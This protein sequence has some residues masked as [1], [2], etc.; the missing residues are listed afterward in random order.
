MLDEAIEKHELLKH[1]PPYARHWG[2]LMSRAVYEFYEHKYIWDAENLG[3][4][5]T[6]AGFSKVYQD[7]PVD[8]LD[9]LADLRKD[10]SFYMQAEV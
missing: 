5:L 6:A 9:N 10:S 2:D 4:A 7:D 3:V 8:G 1:M